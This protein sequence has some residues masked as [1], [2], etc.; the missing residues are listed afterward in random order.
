MSG[1][2]EKENTNR[3]ILQCMQ[4]EFCLYME[5]PGYLAMKDFMERVFDDYYHFSMK[6]IRQNEVPRVPVV[7]H[8]QIDGQTI[9]TNLKKFK[10]KKIRSSTNKNFK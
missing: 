6:N 4:I 10:T 7:V 2:C 8:T 9:S 1:Y 5:S 3:V